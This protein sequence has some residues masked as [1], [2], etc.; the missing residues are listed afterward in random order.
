VPLFFPYAEELVATGA[1]TEHI[2][3]TMMR[4]R[5]VAEEAGAFHALEEPEKSLKRASIEP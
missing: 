2:H 1:Q 5:S 4:L 3:D